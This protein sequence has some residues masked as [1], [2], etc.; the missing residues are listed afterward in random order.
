M[1]KDRRENVTLTT[2]G[3][4]GPLEFCKILNGLS[5]PHVVHDDFITVEL[6]KTK[7]RGHNVTLEL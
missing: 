7:V 5:P 3:G 1:T 4:E 2:G 6:K